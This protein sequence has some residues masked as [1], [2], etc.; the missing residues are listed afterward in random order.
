LLSTPAKGIINE[1]IFL[2]R[3]QEIFA[4]SNNYTSGSGNGASDNGRELISRRE[5]RISINTGQMPIVGPLRNNPG[6][7]DFEGMILALR[8]LFESD[9]QIASQPDSA[10]CGICYLH[11]TT[12]ELHYREEEGFYVCRSC[13]RT[14]G[15]QQMP[16]LRRQQK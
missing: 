3:F 16:M 1:V 2:V 8:E 11:Y 4:L 14:L 7:F 15:K 12:N 9:R 10:R 5:A 6:T 13:E